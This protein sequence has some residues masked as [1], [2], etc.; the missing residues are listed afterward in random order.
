MRGTRS[1]AHHEDVTLRRTLTLTGVALAAV[2]GTGALAVRDAGGVQRAAITVDV[3]HPGPTV[4]ASFR[5]LLARGAGGR[6]LRG[7]GSAS[8]RRADAPARDPRRRAG[9]AGRAAH[10]GQHDRRVLVGS[11]SGAG[12]RPASRAAPASCSALAGSGGCRGSRARRERRSRSASTS[13]PTT[14]AARWPLLARSG[15]RCR[16]GRCE[17]SRSATSPICTPA[18]WPSAAGRVVVRRVAPP[19]PLRPGALHGGRQPLRRGAL[20]RAGSAIPPSP[21]AASAASRGMPR[22]PRCC[23]ASRAASVRSA[24]TPT[25]STAVPGTRGARSSCTG[26][27]PTPPAAGWPPAS[28]GWWPSG[29]A[30]ACPCTSPR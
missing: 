8:Q 1:R 21:P 11:R 30:Q 9:L 22:W 18:A 2:A 15:R 25:R 26:C 7:H 5:G 13:P 20:G 6:R 17:R 28:R 3:A 23:A 4:P 19:R 16:P 24:P 12:L 14:P 27:S 29:A 10:R